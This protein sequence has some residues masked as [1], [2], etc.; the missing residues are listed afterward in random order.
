MSRYLCIHGHY[1]QPP[2]ENPWLEA[3]EQQDTAYPFH[4]WNERITAECYEPN[5]AARILDAQRQIAAIVN[6]Y[7]RTSFNFGPTLLSWLEKSRPVTYQRILEADRLSRERFSG[8]G[9]ALAQPYNHLIMPLATQ[10]DRQTQIRWGLADFR[11]RFGREAE[12]IW[13]PEAAVDVNTLELL[14]DHGL[15]FTVLAPHQAARIRPRDQ[16]GWQ[17]L[18]GADIDPRRPYRCRLPSGAEIA[19]FFY[20]GPIARDVA[21]ARLL[22]DGESFAQRLVDTFADGDSPQLVHVATDGETYGHHHRFGEMALAYCLDVL[23]RRQQVRLTVYGEYLALHPPQDEVEIRS[24]SSWSCAHGV[25][26]WRADCGCHIGGEAGWTQS[27]RAP[28]RQALDWL[29]DRLAPLFVT[30][31]SPYCAD[32]W[33]ARDAYIDLVLDRSAAARESFFTTHLRG[34]LNDEEAVKVLGLLEMQRHA[35]L[36]YTSCGWFFDE[37]S[38]IET[39]QI[40]AYAGRALQLAEE[41][42]GIP[43][44]QEFLR[45]LEQVPSNLRRIGNAA[46]LYASQVSPSRL[47]LTRVAAHHAIVTSFG[48]ECDPSRSMRQDLHCYSIDDCTIEKSAN[49]RMHLAIGNSVI[50]SQ[51]TLSAERVSFAVLNLGGHAVT[52]GVARDDSRQGLAVLREELVEPFRQTNLAEVVRAMDRHFG[53]QNFTLLHLFKDDQRRVLQQLMARTLEEI[54]GSFRGIYENHSSFLRFLHQLDMPTPRLLALPVEMVLIGRFRTLFE[55]SQP[56][57]E[58]LRAL[59]D[60]VEALAIPLDEPMLGVAAGRQV[61]QLLDKLAIAPRNLALLLTLTE[62]LEVLSRLPFELDLWQ[63]QNRFW[64]ILHT[65]HDDLSRTTVSPDSSDDWPSVFRRLGTLL[66]VQVP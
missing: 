65:V 39:T 14:V 64:E 32:P 28:L 42:S 30:G 22:D 41:A 38:G 58:R 20:D 21:F 56:Q 57:P 55:Q 17:E 23:E 66:Q 13:L 59:A 50:R 11:H 4:D 61:Q 6:N 2:R 29:R 34:P 33:G 18:N 16:Q 5:G 54:E 44:E 62:T 37:V 7:A 27:W 40:L 53:S 51:I 24:N 15:R 43:L 9:A 8:H 45:H 36:M 31:L 1:Y 60:E 46:R 12:G 35:Q 63:A 3:V 26:R 47:D 49:G 10:R 48:E 52:A 25:E 19:L